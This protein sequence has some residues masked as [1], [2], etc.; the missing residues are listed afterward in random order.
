MKSINKILA[1][2]IF[3][4]VLI[5]LLFFICIK[6][7][8]SYN[9]RQYRVDANR[10]ANKI[11]SDGFES[12]DLSDYSTITAVVLMN[13][14]N[15]ERFF[16]AESDYIIRE[17]DGEIYRIEYAPNK[18][19]VTY[20]IITISSI[21]LIVISMI[22]IGILFYIRQRILKP[23]AQL[24]EAPYELS[25][26]NLTVPIME[27][28]DRFFGKFTWGMNL[29]RENLERSK[30]RELELQKEKK[31]LLISL[32]HDIKT[33][34]SAI[35]LYSKAL[36]KGLYPDSKKQT[37][38]F[39]NI[40]KKADEIEGFVREIITAS[41]EE[42]LELEVEQGE[43]YLSDVIDKIAKYYNEKLSLL[44]ID[45][46]VEKYS[47]CIL[48]GDSDRVVESIQNIIENSVKYGDGRIISIEFSDEEECKLITVKNSGCTLSEIELPHIFN[49]FWRGS[50]VKSNQ[51]S[52]LGLYICHQLI[53]KMNGEV[54]AEVKDNF[55]YV[56]I[57]LNKC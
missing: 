13:E 19:D 43:F 29:L 51:G 22:T 26:G 38:I 34:L 47:D 6:N 7:I 27:N 23:F 55:M 14:T 50:N 21:F 45:F 49:S 1:V 35:K 42:F 53:H 40:N 16:E 10:I 54:F 28:K 12:I 36:L 32:S 3:I 20:S 15:E 46:T 48:K 18:N 44:N 37:E 57:V 25:K 31:T 17:I 9:G 41:S 24:R 2:V 39:E 56:T 33:P 5:I 52:G 8:S 11:S 30:Q 4:I